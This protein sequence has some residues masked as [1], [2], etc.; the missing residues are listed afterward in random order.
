MRVKYNLTRSVHFVDWTAKVGARYPEIKSRAGTGCW[1]VSEAHP[2]GKLHT[3]YV[4]RR[5]R[6]W[7]ST[8]LVTFDGRQLN[9][10]L[11]VS[12]RVHAELRE[13]F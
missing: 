2:Q 11:A 5:G 10:P 8:M 9:V 6:L 12:R 7:S 4:H 1:I 3:V 13:T